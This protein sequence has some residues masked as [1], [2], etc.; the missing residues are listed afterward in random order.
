MGYCARTVGTILAAAASVCTF[1]AMAQVEPATKPADE[2]LPVA[3]S[4]APR[5]EGKSLTRDVQMSGNIIKNYSA[6]EAPVGDFLQEMSGLLNKNIVASKDVRGTISVSMSNVTPMELLDAVL[7]MNGFAYREKGNFIYVYTTKEM[8]QLEKSERKMT[9]EIF[10]L[11][12]VPA[13]VALDMIEGAR[14]P[15]APKAAIYKDK[16]FTIDLSARTVEYS[17]YSAADMLVVTDYPDV[18]EKIRQIVKDLDK[19]PQQVLVEATI[20]QAKLDDNNAMGVDFTLLGGVDFRSLTNA[21]AT[22]NDALGGA[23]IDNPNAGN[24]NDKGYTG[25][26]TRNLSVTDTKGLNVGLVYNNVGV[27]VNALEAVTD[28][29]VLAN[30]KVLTLNKQPGMVLVGRRNGYYTVTTTTTASQQNVEFLETGTRLIFKPFIAQDGFIRMIIHPE[31][32]T[33]GLNNLGL[34]D[35]ETTEI[36]SNVLVKDGHTIV[37]GGLF[38]ENNSISRSQVPFLGDLP[39]AGYLFRRQADIVNRSEVIVLLT[40]HIIKNESA[41]TTASEEQLSRADQLVMGLRKGMMP[42]S[43][44]RLSE[45]AYDKARAEM[46]QKYPDREKA[47]W[48]LDCATC[49][50]PAFGE[51]IA[52]KEALASKDIAAAEQSSIRYFVRR[53]ALADMATEDGSGEPKVLSTPA[54]PPL[55]LKPAPQ[56]VVVE[57]ATQSIDRTGSSGVKAAEPAPTDAIEVK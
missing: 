32:S 43:R 46:Q 27:F 17:N 49:L 19:R 11:S 47:M 40:P 3:A 51:A 41:Y 34:P 37:I 21:G 44:A 24:I 38:R 50:S 4:A 15:D 20:L 6:S 33:G 42:F 36:T 2:S 26:G 22:A 31:D 28:S 48:Y 45:I 39:L 54:V 56:P 12:Y 7:H 53:Q 13:N 52:M 29:V 57:P 8:E 10:H 14:S 1:Q 55:E 18:M 30:P 25:V 16:D 9:T 35:K 5:K 23:I